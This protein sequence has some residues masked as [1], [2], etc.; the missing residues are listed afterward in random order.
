MPVADAVYT[1]RCSTDRRRAADTGCTAV[2]W[3]RIAVA[4]EGLRSG[5]TEVLAR[6]A[7]H[8]AGV[9]HT[10]GVTTLRRGTSF[11]CSTTMARVIIT[12]AA[13][14]AWS[15]LAQMLAG[16][17]FSGA[18]TINTDCITTLGF[19]TIDAACSAMLRIRFGIAGISTEMPVDR[20]LNA[21]LVVYTSRFTAGR[22]RTI[23]AS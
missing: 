6:V 4:A 23:R 20:A 15:G 19:R 11:A 5:L 7:V 18:Y 2:S 12:V 13:P 14:D 16:V 22:R 3:I 21:A 10:G 8:P 17:T 1:H 9:V